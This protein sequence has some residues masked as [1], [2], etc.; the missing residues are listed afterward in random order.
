[1]KLFLIV[2][3]LISSLFSKTYNFTETRYSDAFDSSL[4]LDGIISFKK[5]GLKINYKNDNRE[6]LYEDSLLVIKENEKVLDID[7]MQ[8]QS[9]SSFF[10]ILLMIYNNDEVALKENFILK[11]IEN[12][13]ELQ[14]K[15]NI[16]QHIEII[17][18]L[19][20]QEQTKEVKLFLKNGDSIT[21]RIDDEIR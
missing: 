3:M 9:V 5:H 4:D 1:M 17:S 16:S 20:V 7:A 8:I 14:P 15:N 13:I 18:V 10:E 21:I 19:K 11:N 6:I 2:L 12:K